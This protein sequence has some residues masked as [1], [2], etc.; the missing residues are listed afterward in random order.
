MSKRVILTPGKTLS[1]YFRGL[2]LWF[3]HSKINS[4]DGV[5]P[6]LTANL[7]ALI[8][9][10]V[11]KMKIYK[12]FRA[13]SVELILMSCF[14]FLSAGTFAQVQLK[15]TIVIWQHHKFDLNPDYSISSYSTVD[16]DIE[17]I[18]FSNAKVIENELIRL[19]LLPEYGARI[20]SFY[21]KPTGHEYLY[22]SECGSPYGIGGGTFYYDW[23][24]VYGGIFPTFPEP[25]H[26]KTWFL[27]WEYS[28][29]KNNS[30]TVTIRMEYFDDSEY[31]QAPVSFNNGITNLTCQVDISVYKNSSIWD[32]EV[33]LINDQGANVNYEYWTCTTLAPGSEVGDT[34]TPL[35]SEIIIPAEQYFAGWSPGNWIGN[36]NASYDLTNIDFLSE[37]DDM[38]IAY[39]EDFDGTFWGVINHEN[40]EGIFRIS[41]NTETKGVKL[42]TWGK[43]NIDNN[44]FDFSNGGADNYIELWAGVSESFFTDAVIESNEQKSWK[45]SYCA[46][47]NLS[48]I[49]NIN[50]IA[51]VNLIWVNEESKLSYELNT[52]HADR[53]YT[54]EMFLE[55]NNFSEEITSHGV[56]FAGLGQAESFLLDGLN[57][58][59]GAY[60]VYFDLTDELGNL[61]FSASKVISV[62]SPM[63]SKDLANDGASE[64]V[65]QLLGNQRI[66]AELSVIGDYQCQVFSI[67]G[68]LLSSLQFSGKSVDLQ[69]PTSGLFLIVIY[70]NKAFF[71]Q[72][73][74]VP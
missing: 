20:L 38:G 46:T 70:K 24:M 55:G 3:G 73:V 21:Y 25:E 34:G 57:L 13:Y 61:V 36:Y 66:R 14:S 5:F 63:S 27:P 68:Q 54:L 33:H 6:I 8:T 7:A 22:Q 11:S 56:D 32:F 16:T 67:N 17:E 50:E 72:K 1:G 15:D 48:S 74:F 4:N 19:V 69:F 62:S 60:T 51:A 28:V 43:N 10:M 71:T 30:D 31:V 65:I 40:E 2:I 26:G 39:A 49:C 52:F 58:T 12:K 42:W 9:N 47:V 29:I 41:E 59:P 35:N 37:W 45:E 18:V 64:L 53:S 23:L 44:L